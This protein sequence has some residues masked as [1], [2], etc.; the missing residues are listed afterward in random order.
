M[1]KTKHATAPSN[2]LATVCIIRFSTFANDS[3]VVISLAP[4]RGGE[5]RIKLHDVHPADGSYPAPALA[6]AQFGLRL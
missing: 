5:Q 2:D 1:I 3:S 6:L 4:E